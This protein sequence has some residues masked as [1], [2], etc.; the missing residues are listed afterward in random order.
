MPTLLLRFPGGRYH[1]TPWGHHVNEGLIEWPPSPWRLLRALL[2]TGYTALHWDGDMSRP[3][4]CSPPDDA[5]SLILK[6]ASQLPVYRLPS[7]A[8]SHTRH[9]MPLGV[10]EKGREKTTLVFDTW[11]KVGDGVLAVTWDV[12]LN[13]DETA[14]LARLAEN[15]GY[16]GRSESWV[17]ARLAKSGERVTEGSDCFSEIGQV[18]PGPGWEQI[19]LIAPLAA[20]D[21]LNWRTQQVGERLEQLP[22][23]PLPEKKKITQKD[24][25]P[26]EDR[27]AE[28]VNAEAPYPS[29]FIAC[30]QVDTTELRRHGW[31]QPPGSRRV[32]FWR[33]TDALEA[34]APKPRPRTRAVPAVEAMLLSMSTASGNDHTLPNITRTLPQAELLHRALVGIASRQNG[35]SIVLSGCDEHRQP[36]KQP[37]RHAHILPLD[38]D[39]DG[40]LE[41]ILIW[42]PM[43]LDAN[44]QAAIRAVRQTFTKGGVGSLKLALE[45]VGNLDNL[46]QLR[47]IYGEGMR[48]LLSPTEGATRWITRTPFVPPRYV[49]PHG[50]N[51]L[52]GQVAAELASR[53]LSDLLEVKRLDPVSDGK[54]SIRLLDPDEQ[55]SEIEP[56]NRSPDWLRFRHFVRTRRQGTAAPVDFG[57]ALELRFETP[58][59]GPIALGY[60]C[61]FGLGLFTPAHPA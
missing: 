42:A 8:G 4:L 45:A 58:Q 7:G 59:R 17:E 35:H 33:K 54:A 38:L 18:N 51:S 5:R 34:G 28:R 23:I 6:L 43:G 26:S 20:D 37:H 55:Q 46:R 12:D 11:A 30:L 9:Y 52:E 61:H 25:K 31:S 41:H 60:G 15:M 19:P 21:Y 13:E 47:G 27:E 29:D 2:S 36:L 44:A 49:K 22:P 24:R 1:A 50:A 10:I 14:L 3:M 56:S 57:F 53:G 40:H 48:A 39:G 32:F 16:L